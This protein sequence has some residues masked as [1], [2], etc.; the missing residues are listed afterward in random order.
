VKYQRVGGQILLKKLA[1]SS[2]KKKRG[3]LV[4]FLAYNDIGGEWGATYS[5]F[6]KK[7][8]QSLGLSEQVS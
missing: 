7:K 1:S 2:R 6:F 4:E 8:G 5:P 3:W